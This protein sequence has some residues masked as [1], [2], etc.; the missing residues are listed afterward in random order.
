M[1]DWH[2]H[3]YTTTYASD[4]SGVCSAMFELGGMTILHDPSGCNSTYTTHDEPR[5][6]GSRSLMFVSGLDEMTAVMGD[7]SVLLGDAEKAV[8]DLQPRFVTLC[9][10]SIPHIIGFDT[11]GVAH[12]LEQRTGVPVLA[13]RTDGL[14]SYVSG[15]GR[16]LEAWLERF[17]EAEEKTAEKTVNLLGVT[18]LDFS[19][20]ENVEAMRSTFEHHGWRV[21]A[22]LAMGDTF[23]N[24]AH[25]YR[26]RAN[27]VVSSAGLYPAK[28][29]WARK[30]IPYVVGLPVGAAG[31]QRVLSCLDQAVKEE[32]PQCA[33]RRHEKG[34][35]LIIG[36]EVW[37]CSLAESFPNAQAVWPDVD[38]GLDE[39]KL[40]E[41]IN[42]AEVVIADPLYRVL[43]HNPRVRFIDFP[44]EGASGRLFRRKIPAFAGEAFDPENLWKGQ[45]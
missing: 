33:Y 28:K 42:A 6:Y 13:V 26:A 16:A 43:L 24:L 21:N 32:K 9:G 34:S 44:H 23:E 1:S 37:A 14:R 36:E 4:V 18:P 41:Q 22:V 8:K 5:W 20:L 27:V 38:E 15:V 25:A 29:M 45:V 31:T 40:E 30:H 7:D 2:V 35:V 11:P 19:R 39:E 10:A 12:L 3:V 17:A